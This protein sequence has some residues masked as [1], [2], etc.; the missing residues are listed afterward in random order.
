MR[1]KEKREE[2]IQDEIKEKVINTFFSNGIGSGFSSDD[3]YIDF[4][5]YPEERD[6][7]V[8]T[9]RVFLTPLSFKETL[10]FLKERLD[11]YEKEYGEIKEKEKSE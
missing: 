3:F 4:M 7:S 1:K 9:T 2:A 11:D 5:Q 10:T 8:I 6:G